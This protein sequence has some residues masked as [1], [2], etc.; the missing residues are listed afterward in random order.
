[1]K[2]CCGNKKDVSKKQV[3]IK[4]QRKTTITTTKTLPTNTS[5]RATKIYTTEDIQAP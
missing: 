4:E 2:I 3:T 1:M 5:I